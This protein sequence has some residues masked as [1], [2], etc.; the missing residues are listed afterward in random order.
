MNSS[1][2]CGNN[3]ARRGFTLIELLVVI[4]IIAILIGLLL[5]AVQKVREAAARAT[6]Q[7]NLKQIGLALH[8]YH[9]SYNYYPRGSSD[10]PSVT[11]CAG[12][13]RNEWTWMYQILPFV[14]LQTLYDAPD[15]T[16]ETTAVKIYY[17]PSR[18]PPRTYG[19][20]FAR[21]DYAGN[22]G[23]FM[24][25][26]G[27]KGMFM[28]TWD[29][30]PNTTLPAPVQQY[31]RLA[32]ITDGLSNTIAVGEKQCHPTVL[33]KAGGDNER[34]NNSGWDE[35][36]VR[37]GSNSGGASG[38]QGGIAPDSQHPGSNSPTYWSRK[39]GSS[40][41][42]G[43]NFLFGDGAVRNVSFSV[44]LEQFRRMCVI[45]DGLPVTIN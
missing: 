35:D 39:F 20:G 38:N 9:D 42:S 43:V 13:T 34:W 16:V 26:W 29:K 6:C 19:S 41:P 28:R 3:L 15:A 36:N 22:G 30:L 4:A 14:E 31:R 1:Q 37:F 12:D 40:H 21:C 2:N 27:A 17:C 11:C 24:S 32:D 23:E 18:R 44:D 25:E 33:G 8:N 7:N 10:G 5:P 45:N